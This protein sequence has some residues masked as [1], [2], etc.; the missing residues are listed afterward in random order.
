[1]LMSTKMEDQPNQSLF[2]NIPI[3]KSP[4]KSEISTS[5]EQSYTLISTRHSHAFWLL[6][7]SKQSESMSILSVFLG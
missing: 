2:L 6:H 4:S 7:R 1:M 5:S 3:G